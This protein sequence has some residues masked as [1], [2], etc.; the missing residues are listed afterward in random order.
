MITINEIL[1]KKRNKMVVSPITMEDGELQYSRTCGIVEEFIHYGY[2]PSE[3]LIKRLLVTPKEH[4]DIF[5]GDLI[6]L[7][8]KLKGDEDANMEPLYPNFPEIYKTASEIELYLTS[9]LYYISNGDFNLINE[10]YPN[11]SQPQ[12]IDNV[13]F[14]S[15][16][17]VSLGT[18]DDGIEILNNIINSPVSL[19]AFDKSI[20]KFAF[21][22][23]SNQ[24]FTNVLL[25]SVDDPSLIP[26]KETKIL[27]V[28][29]AYENNS[30]D[31]VDVLK[32]IKTPTDVLRFAV[33]I[34]GDDTDISLARP[35]KFKLDNKTRI[36]VLRLINKIGLNANNVD[37]YKKYS[38]R[39]KRLGVCVHSDKFNKRFPVA[40]SVFNQIRNNS[41]KHRGYHSRLEEAYDNESLTETLGLLMQRPGELVR[42]L[43]RFGVMLSNGNLDTSL[44]LPLLMNAFS[45]FV[46]RSTSIQQPQFRPDSRT[47]NIK[48][49]DGKVKLI[50]YNDKPIA[51]AVS[52][53]ILT[54]LRNTIY[55]KIRQNKSLSSW[56]GEKIFIDPA[57]QFM[58]L[59]AS[60]RSASDATMQ[61]ERGSRIFLPPSD[62]TIND[63]TKD[64]W[65]RA[66]IF[67][68]NQPERTVDLDLSLVLFNANLEPV[69]FINYGNISSVECYHSGDIRSGGID[70]A[71]E[72]IDF[73]INKLKKLDIA[74]VGMYVNSYNDQKLKDIPECSGGIMHVEDPT[75]ESVFNPANVIIRTTLETNN[76]TSMMMVIDTTYNQMIWTD[77]KVTP[78]DIQYPNSVAYQLNE[79]AQMVK[80][81]VNATN[82]KPNLRELFTI[83]AFNRGGKVVPNKEDASMIFS[84]DPSESV[85]SP[86]DNP[87]ISGEYLNI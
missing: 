72:Y 18:A 41:F 19:S 10:I 25:S 78:S 12:K 61:M 75:Q 24:H 4:L 15:L 48:G 38:E 53:S 64:T 34:S 33:A 58:L 43:D 82:V 52:N 42:N 49:T 57:L 86:W 21:N 79:S 74:Y 71:A 47:V 14:D 76:R 6:A 27:C 65:L 46:S 56:E 2:L 73:S 70:G 22:E 66:F 26:F 59:P 63:E 85:V 20:I 28:K 13:K 3:D 35:C 83:H 87:T 11:L 44:P 30:L 55:E 29:L 67:W 45:H 8:K 62:V 17:K 81:F 77:C 31:I 7:L 84:M 37:E 23:I 9:F 80:A 39:F 36:M 50:P 16:V 54:L 40:S 32:L 69:D 60:A 1:M 68:K 51:M 5:Y